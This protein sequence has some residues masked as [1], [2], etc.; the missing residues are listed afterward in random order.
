M[1]ES[2]S[3]VSALVDSVAQ[4]ATGGI[5]AIFSAASAIL[6]DKRKLRQ[7]DEQQEKKQ[8]QV[9]VNMFA[10]EAGGNNSII[11]DNLKTIE[12][13][14]ERLDE[15]V[16]NSTKVKPIA[17][18]LFPLKNQAWSLT[19]KVLPKGLI[20]DNELLYSIVKISHAIDMVNVRIEYRR[21]I[22]EAALTDK[23]HCYTLKECDELIRADL[24][25]IRE[26]NVEFGKLVFPE[27]LQR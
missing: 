23:I 14:L 22:F 8:L 9:F 17:A 2:T 25:Q 11:M 10:E 1:L 16:K 5:I 15:C 6:W 12:L 19:R 20:E 24:E 21:P 3:T 13:N 7:A 4:L 27:E 26:M 18:P